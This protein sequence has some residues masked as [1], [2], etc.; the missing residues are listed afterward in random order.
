MK[1]PEEMNT[2][3][4][5]GAAESGVGAA[6]LAQAKEYDVF[7]SDLGEIKQEYKE[8]LDKY[9]LEYE[10]NQHTE[11]RILAADCIIKSP[12]IPDKAPLIK[13]A[14][15]KGIPVIS[16]IEWASWFTNATCIGITE[17]RQLLP[18]PIIS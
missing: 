5:L 2:I 15:E 8:E 18:S 10:E 11:N 13:K 16:E 7:V 12:G 4:V 9:G 6:I 1:G 17:R 3:V 14:H